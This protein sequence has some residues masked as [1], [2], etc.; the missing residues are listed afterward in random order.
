MSD[1]NRVSSLNLP[2][3]PGILPYGF[4]ISN[5]EQE[6]RSNYSAANQGPPKVEAHNISDALKFVIARKKRWG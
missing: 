2:K 3:Y 6:K 5:V 1:F 4:S